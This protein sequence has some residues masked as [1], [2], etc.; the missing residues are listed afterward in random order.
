MSNVKVGHFGGRVT[1]RAL[2]M[3]ALDDVKD[4]DTVI[5]INKRKLDENAFA[6]A[7]GYSEGEPLERL[8]VLSLAREHLIADIEDY[9][10]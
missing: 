10:G 7:V 8:G 3:S 9:E 2:L 5:V 1:A 4:D 6:L